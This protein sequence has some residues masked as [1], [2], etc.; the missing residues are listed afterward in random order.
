MNTAKTIPIKSTE[1]LI[2][3][4]AGL[5]RDIDRK[6]A[7]LRDINQELATLA[8]FKNDAKTGYLVGA[9]Y[10]VKVQLKE[11]IAWDQEK[12][13][14]LRDNIPE[15]QFQKLFRMLYEPVARKAIDGFLAHA[16]K[17]LAD[18]VRWAMTVKPGAPQVTYEPLE[19]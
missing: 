10:K 19:E 15:E 12:L 18:G 13:H 9:G 8:E 11:N 1:D 6:T 2:R 16:E 3:E 17:D 14:M 4:G 7:R 5:K